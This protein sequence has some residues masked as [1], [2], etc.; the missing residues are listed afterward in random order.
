MTNY[1]DKN[2]T[3]LELKNISKSFPG[4]IAL[5]NVDFNVK[6]RE[7]HALIGENGAGKSTL[8]RIILGSHQPTSGEMFFKGKRYQPKAPSDALNMGISMIHQEISLIP[9]LSVSD[10]IW[11]GREAAFGNKLF[12]NMKKQEVASKVIIEQLGLDIS[13]RTEVCKLSIAQMQLVEIARAVSYNADIIIMDEPTSALADAEVEKLY[14]IISNLKDE[15]KSVIFISHKLEEVLRICDTV[16]VLRDGHFIKELDAEKTSK[17][18]LVSLMVGREMSNVYPKEIVDIGGPVFEVKNFSQ[19]GVFNNVSFAVRKGEILGFSGL[20]GS[21]RTEIMRAIFGVDPH[22]TGSLMLNGKQIDI[23]NSADAVR[24][25]LSMVTEDRLRCGA[26]HA[27]PVKFNASIAYLRKIT[28]FG[29]VIQMQEKTDVQ[30]MVDK[31]SIK[32]SNLDNEIGLL[33]GGNQQKVIIAKWLLTQPEVLILDEPTRGIDVGAKAEI[34]KLICS[35]AKQ[36]KAIIFISSELPEVMG[37]SDRILVVREG[38]IA[39]E[40]LRDDFDQKRIMSCAF[41]A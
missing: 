36:G 16:T 22:Q 3:I 30:D 26:I 31:L 38:Q 14:G 2:E 41:G 33:S 39:G 18:E 7:V 28:R 35:L 15:G 5:K 23:K 25:K 19:P 27:L 37:I 1:D 10:N 21:G 13:P 8:M 32:V 20:I 4:V 6:Q 11:L 34:Y 24:N 17:D 40:F 12:I 29:F 9:S